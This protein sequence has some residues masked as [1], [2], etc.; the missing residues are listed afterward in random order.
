MKS[1][2][3]RMNSRIHALHETAQVQDSI[4]LGNMAEINFRCLTRQCVS[5]NQ[6]PSL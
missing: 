4:Y 2:I 6:W 1:A 5:N 3:W